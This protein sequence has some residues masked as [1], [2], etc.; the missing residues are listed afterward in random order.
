MKFVDTQATEVI[1][2]DEE[3][4]DSGTDNPGMNYIDVAL[5]IKKHSIKAY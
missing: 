1:S 2:G 4:D 3:N 5:M